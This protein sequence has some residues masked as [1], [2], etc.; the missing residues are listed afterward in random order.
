MIRSGGDE[1]V[2][3]LPRTSLAD[4]DAVV[5]DLRAQMTLTWS[6]GVTEWAAEEEIDVAWARADA[7]MY[8]N[9]AARPARP[10]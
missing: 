2:L 1:F 8:R 9:K 6:V 4:V 3:I 5:S 10:D 7:Q